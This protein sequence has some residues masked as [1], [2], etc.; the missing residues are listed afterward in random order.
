MPTFFDPDKALE[1]ITELHGS[2][3]PKDFERLLE[4]VFGLDTHIGN[5]R[6][7]PKNWVR[8]FQAAQVQD[9]DPKA[10]GPFV[11]VTTDRDTIG[12][13]P[14]T[15]VRACIDC[16]VL[17]VGGPTRCLYCASKLVD[18]ELLALRSRPEKP[19]EPPN[20]ELRED[21]QPRRS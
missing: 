13:G 12:L 18:P 10:L 1:E 5:G 14:F 7:P 20:R 21:E 3:G 6:C 2:G 16:G 4:L 9:A 19:K 11:P 15:T 8:A 17:I